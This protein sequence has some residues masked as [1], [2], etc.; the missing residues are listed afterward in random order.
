MV[1]D[2]P[3]K[4]LTD[5]A[6]VYDQPTSEP[7]HLVSARD[8]KVDSVPRLVREEVEGALLGLLQHPTIASKK[9]VWKQYDHMVMSG[10]TV[11]PGSD[12]GVV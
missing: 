11:E 6:P 3:A 9:W 5:E 8:W 10:C 4:S 12:A 2:L 1:A 7:A